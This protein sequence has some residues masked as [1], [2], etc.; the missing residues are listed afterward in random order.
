M[1]GEQQEG[2][3]VFDRARRQDRAADAGQG[4]PSAAGNDR[5]RTHA[6][7]GSSEEVTFGPV[8]KMKPPIIFR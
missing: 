7:E 6:E 1:K 2:F 3:V 8:Q 4:R 5:C